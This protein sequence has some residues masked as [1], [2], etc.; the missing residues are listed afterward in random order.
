[1]EIELAKL[2]GLP[3]H[4]LLVHIPVVLVPL[5]ALGAIVLAVSGRLRPTFGW[6]VVALI[7]VGFVGAWLATG[8]GEK[9]EHA[10]DK[11]ELVHDH[12]EA[13]ENVL[14]V[15][16]AF[17]VA[18]AA[19]MVVDRRRRGSD[20]TNRLRTAVVVLAVLSAATGV[21]AT[22]AVIRAGHSGAKAVWDD[23]KVLNDLSD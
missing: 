6:I 7:A 3:A 11:S 5:A 1:V 20:D 13:G 19:L 8:S 12:T 14:P 10:V 4:A 22:A 17:L 21:G 15:T 9:L 23:E 18:T 2:F 16:G